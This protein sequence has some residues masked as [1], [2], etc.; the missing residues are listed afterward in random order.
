VIG[1]REWPLADDDEEGLLF[2]LRS[3]AD[4]KEDEV[5]D[6]AMAAARGMTGRRRKRLT[7]RPLSSSSATDWR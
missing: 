5:E 6:V 4:E 1:T 7:T 3:P 2:R